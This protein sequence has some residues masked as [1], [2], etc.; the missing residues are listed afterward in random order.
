VGPAAVA[1]P[2]QHADH[3][4]GVSGYDGEICESGY[5]RNDILCAPTPSR[6]PSEVRARWA[7]PA[8]KARVIVR[9]DLAGQPVYASGRLPL[10]FRL[11]LEQAWRRLGDDYV[12]LLRGHHHHGRYVPAGSRPGFALNVTAYPTSP[13]LFP[14]HRRGITDYSSVMFDFAPTGRPLLSSPTTG[15]VRDE[16]GAVL[17]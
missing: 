1:Q 14:G 2:V 3:A 11:D 4:P 5:P 15:A 9:A 13:R 17:L 10:D 7:I 8:G 12:I 6:S 16:P